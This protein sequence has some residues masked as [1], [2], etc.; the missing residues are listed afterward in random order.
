MDVPG[1]SPAV[2]KICVDRLAGI[3][4]FCGGSK[5]A[6][7]LITTEGAQVRTP[8]EQVGC[9]DDAVCVFNV[10]DT[11]N[12]DEG[13]C[14]RPC[15][16]D[17]DEECPPA[18]PYCNPVGVLVDTS[19]AGLCSERRIGFGSLSAYRVGPHRAGVVTACDAAAPELVTLDLEPIDIPAKLCVEMCNE[20]GS[21]PDVA[22]VSTDATNPVVCRVL[23]ANTGG[24]M[25]VHTNAG[26]FPDTCGDGTSASGR[27]AFGVEFGQQDPIPAAWCVDRFEPALAPSA[28]DLAGEVIVDGH[29]CDGGVKPFFCPEPT[30]CQAIDTRGRCLVG[31]ALGGEPTYCE[32]TLRALGLPA[33]DA[34]CLMT[35]TSTTDGLCGG[36]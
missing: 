13:V 18:F 35:G 4:A 30:H 15:G 16:R 32:R 3:D 11:L 12:P 2:G 33:G 19:T 23:N 36:L 17:G 26:A 9:A 21:Q 27:G 29:I 31:C 6:E 14:L 1:A 22:C 28:L 24:G 10:L 25:C 20:G 34:R 5:N 7:V 8:S